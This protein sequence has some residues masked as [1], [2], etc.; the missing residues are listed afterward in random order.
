MGGAQHQFNFNSCE[1]RDLP[2]SGPILVAKGLTACSAR[3]VAPRYA[4]PAERGGDRRT[5][6]LA[7]A[8]KPR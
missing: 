4:A 6:R 1:A 5:G 7:L 2:D 3:G 8:G